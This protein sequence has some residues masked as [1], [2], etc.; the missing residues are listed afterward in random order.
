MRSGVLVP[1]L[2]GL[3]V[4]AGL[5]VAFV[6]LS[7]GVPTGKSSTVIIPDGASTGMNYTPKVIKVAVGV[8]STVRWVNQD[9]VLHSVAADNA[10]DPSFYAATHGENLTFIQPGESF[11]YTFT[12]PGMYDYHGEPG[13]WMQG[14]V[15]VISG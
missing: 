6:L 13:P 11:E 1:A 12:K 14:T 10:D 9:A 4:G 3:A 7:G 15:L 2:V 8:N 5:V